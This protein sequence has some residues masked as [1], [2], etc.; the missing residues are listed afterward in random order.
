MAKTWYIQKWKK[1]Y[2]GE[3]DLVLSKKVLKNSISYVRFIRFKNDNLVYVNDVNDANIVNNVHTTIPIY[4][5]RMEEQLRKAT[6]YEIH[7]F[8]VIIMS[9]LSISLRVI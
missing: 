6:P 5:D 7:K 2:G 1:T 4:D 9:Q 3:T 8:A